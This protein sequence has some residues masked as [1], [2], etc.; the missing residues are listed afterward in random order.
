MGETEIGACDAERSRRLVARANDLSLDRSDNQF[1]NPALCK[2]MSK[3]ET[4]RCG[5]CFVERLGRYLLYHLGAVRS[6]PLQ[7]DVSMQNT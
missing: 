2:I 1:A 4:W 3:T 7:Q 6:F 5:F